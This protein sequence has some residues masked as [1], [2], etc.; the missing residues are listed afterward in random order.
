VDLTYKEAL[1]YALRLLAGKDYT[2]CQIEGKLSKRFPS[3]AVA[4]VLEYISSKNF[5]NDYRFALNYFQSKMEKGWGRRKI[6]YH[7]KLK[8]ISEEIINA[9]ENDV[10]FDYSFVEK[11]IDR[12]YDLSDRKDR[13]RA[14]RFLSSRGFT[15]GEI[16]NLLERK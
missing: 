5:L 8:G 16:F 14:A 3:D 15:A 6:R 2:V 12:K 1:A 10:E 9:V 7:L 13:E 11:E 4:F